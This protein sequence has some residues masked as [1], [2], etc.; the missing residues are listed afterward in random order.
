MLVVVA[1]VVGLV[2]SISI[3]E[4]AYFLLYSIILFMYRNLFHRTFAKCCIARTLLRAYKYK[5]CTLTG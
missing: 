4:L 5:W 3:R 1:A 2:V